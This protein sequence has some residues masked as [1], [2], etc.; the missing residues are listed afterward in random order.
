MSPGALCW[1]AFSDEAFEQLD[2]DGSGLLERKEVK[3]V[4]MQFGA[5]LQNVGPEPVFAVL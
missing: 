2:D 3:Q 1:Q 5:E 4:V